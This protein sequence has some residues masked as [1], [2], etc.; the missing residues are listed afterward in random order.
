MG[1]TQ[2]L[3]HAEAPQ[4]ANDHI[5]RPVQVT[6]VPRRY[7]DGFDAAPG[8]VGHSDCPA[9]QQ[10]G[11]TT[12]TG[13]IH[14]AVTAGQHPESTADGGAR[15]AETHLAGDTTAARVGD[16]VTA[17][18]DGIRVIIEFRQRLEH[19]RPL[20][21]EQQPGD[22]GEP[23]RRVGVPASADRQV[24]EA[25]ADSHR[26]DLFAAETV[27]GID[28][29]HHLRRPGDCRKV[30]LRC[31]LELAGS[32]LTTAGRPGGRKI[33]VQKSVLSLT[34][35]DQ[36]PGC[37]P[38]SR[39]P[40]TV[41]IS[42]SCDQPGFSPVTPCNLALGCPTVK[43]TNGTAA[44]SIHCHPLS[45]DGTIVMAEAPSTMTTVALLVSRQSLRPTASTPWVRAVREAVRWTRQHGH[46]L[47]SSVG[48]PTWELIT[49]CAA[50]ERVPVHLVLPADRRISDTAVETLTAAF[51]LDGLV[52]QVHRV[53]GR[54]E[55]GAAAMAAR[56]RLIGRL[57]DKLLP[58]SIAPRG[59]M[60][61]LLTEGHRAGKEIITRFQV[62]HV[63]RRERLGY[64]IDPSTLNPELHRIADRFLFHW[65]RTADGPWPDER[66]FDYYRDILSHDRYPRSALDTLRHIL[67]TGRLIASGRRMPQG[68]PT[69]S[70]T[71]LSPEETAPLIR[72]RARYHRMS[73]EPYAVGIHLQA[74]ARLGIRPVVYYEPD[75]PNP[76]AGTEE[77]WRSQSRGRITDWR[78]EEEYRHRGDLNLSGLEDDDIVVIARTAD[79]AARLQAETG[80]RVV[81]FLR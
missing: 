32:R 34:G 72:W 43:A 39:R 23:Y 41:R 76:L 73:F 7:E 30:Y 60:Q 8:A 10:D 78:A 29:R 56:D 37:L 22:I 47:V 33:N 44:P 67:H 26:V 65:T 24:G 62:P 21:V 57:A 38:V 13:N 20:T 18:D 66:P 9:P 69:V 68:I 3:R 55:A 77:V 59:S 4:C 80:R 71:A 2:R 54:R 36:R 6:P 74:A 15:Q 53:C 28:R 5:H 48:I 16:S 75:E 70:F 35:Q 50:L 25:Q 11:F 81:P 45:V 58:I 61:A 49:A 17:D 42:F 19:G 1:D 79:E 31:R 46:H 51:A 64:T 14:R 40:D 12:A 52:V 63:R 27:G